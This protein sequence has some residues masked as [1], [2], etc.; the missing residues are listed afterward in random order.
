MEGDC[1]TVWRGRSARGFFVVLVAFCLGACAAVEPAERRA[2]RAGRLAAELSAMDG[3]VAGNE[4]ELLATTAVEESAALAAVY[5]PVAFPWLNNNLVNSG[6]RK[7]GLCWHWRD[8]L[9]PHLYRLRLRTL[10]VRLATA[11]RG[12][13]FEHNAVVVCGRGRPFSEGLVLDPWRGGGKLVWARVSG[14]RYP[15]VALGEEFT[16]DSLRPLFGK[17]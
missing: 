15:W 2:L 12:Q 13:V 14:D 4:A 5:G 8:D 11:R 1:N 3:R 7:R 9:F 10:E 16:P 6:W 17:R